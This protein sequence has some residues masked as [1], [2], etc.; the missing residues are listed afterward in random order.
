MPLH[1]VKYTQSLHL[2]TVH[3]HD[4][5]TSG[6]TGTMPARKPTFQRIDGVAQRA[7]SFRNAVSDGLQLL[8]VRRGCGRLNA[9]F[10]KRSTANKWPIGRFLFA[11]FSGLPDR[12]NSQLEGPW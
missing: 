12:S 4:T 5:I 3:T 2:Q 6:S 11:Q 1:P 7:T 10:F 9:R 8:S